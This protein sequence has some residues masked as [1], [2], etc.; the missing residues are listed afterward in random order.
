MPSDRD[1]FDVHQTRRK[2]G[3]LLETT[4]AQDGDVAV[5][6]VFARKACNA[7]VLSSSNNACPEES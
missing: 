1:G 4:E 7:A 2:V 3:R 5:G 6:H